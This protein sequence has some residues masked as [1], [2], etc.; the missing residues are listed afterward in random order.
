MESF[1]EQN[2][3]MIN[4]LVEQ[5]VLKDPKII[6][7]FRHVPRHLFVTE[8]YSY[9]AYQDTPLPLVGKSTISQ[10]ATVATMLEYLCLEEG[11]KVLEIGTGSGWNAALMA[12]CVGAKGKVITLEIEPKVAEFAKRNLAK[13][14]L[15]NVKALMKDGSKGYG[16]GA[17]YDRIVYTAAVRAVPDA[18]LAQLKIDGALLAPIGGE[19]EVQVLTKIDKVGKKEFRRSQLGYFQFVPLKEKSG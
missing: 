2:E 16:E 15:R 11:D 14:K 5:G 7:A 9:M 3:R 4:F 13:S 1:E 19:G 6:E 10:P 17:P 18:V 12:F 8:D